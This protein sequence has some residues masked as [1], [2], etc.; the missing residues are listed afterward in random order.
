M[1]QIVFNLSLLTGT[2]LVGAG[3]G[4]EFGLGYGLLAGGAIIVLL[5]VHLARA[6]GVTNEKAKS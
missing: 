5:T 1:K 6:V 4:L 2:A 3:V